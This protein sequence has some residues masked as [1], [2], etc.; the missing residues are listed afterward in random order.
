MTYLCGPV[1]ER[2]IR[3]SAILRDC[4]TFAGRHGI[5]TFW[6]TSEFATLSS[7]RLSGERAIRRNALILNDFS[8][9][10][11]IREFREGL[12]GFWGEAARLL[13]V[14][15]N[16]NLTSRRLGVDSWFVVASPCDTIRFVDMRRHTCGPKQAGAGRRF[17]R[18]ENFKSRTGGRQRLE[19]PPPKMAEGP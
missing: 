7:E 8:R 15:R 12:G 4:S 2:A 14:S 9:N 10:D 16:K 5:A 17:F 1:S 13:T 3:V 18:Y 11:L 19:R 6:H